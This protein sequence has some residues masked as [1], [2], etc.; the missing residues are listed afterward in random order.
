MRLLRQ[1]QL[2]Q[3]GRKSHVLSIAC[4]CVL[5][6]V[7]D[8]NKAVCVRK[9]VMYKQQQLLAAGR[10]TPPVVVNKQQVME[11]QQHHEGNDFD[12]HHH[13]QVTSSKEQEGKRVEEI[14][15]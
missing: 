11:V 14:K 4:L 13:H 2:V 12:H 7:F 9:S 10:Q 8:N 1:S 3:H 6:V 5:C 15:A